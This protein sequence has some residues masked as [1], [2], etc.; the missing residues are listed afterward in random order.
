MKK[1]TTRKLARKPSRKFTSKPA[2]KPAPLRFTCYADRDAYAYRRLSLMYAEDGSRIADESALTGNIGI[3]GRSFDVILQDLFASDFMGICPGMNPD[4]EV[5]CFKEDCISPE[6]V[7]R[8]I[9]DCQVEW[10]FIAKGFAFDGSGMERMDIK[11]FEDYLDTT[12]LVFLQ[13]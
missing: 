12:C 6:A 13:N 2:S 11:R 3:L 1:K 8:F 4:A 5:L 10:L 7:L 9:E